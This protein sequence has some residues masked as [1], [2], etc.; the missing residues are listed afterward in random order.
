MPPLIETPIWTPA[1]N[2]EIIRDQIAAILVVELEQQ[3]TL[4]LPPAE[5]PR[6]FR[7]RAMPWGAL[8]EDPPD[9]RPILNVW[10]DA[11][12]FDGAS[13][14]VVDRQKSDGVFNI[15]AYGFG[16]STETPAGH[17]P[18]DE[19]AALAA[20]GALRLA[21]RILMSGHYTYL[22]MRGVVWR[23]WPNTIGMFQPQMEARPE[24]HVC[25]GRLTLGVAFNEFAPQVEGEPLETLVLEVKRSETGELFFSAEYS[26]P[27]P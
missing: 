20:Q 25:A 12:T 2:V 7:E 24:I 15:D 3:A 1:D 5:R 27:T 13:S 23:R 10:F 11:E 14:S 18:G 9:L 8:V 19:A 21:R 22:G 4:G 16:V 6:V 17:A 26:T